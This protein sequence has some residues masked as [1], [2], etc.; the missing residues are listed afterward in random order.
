MGTRQA[1]H[2]MPNAR[3]TG[4]PVL[5]GEGHHRRRLVQ[6]TLH[7]ALPLQTRSCEHA[8]TERRHFQKWHGGKVRAQRLLQ[9]H[10]FAQAQTQAALGLGHGQGAPAQRRQLLPQGQVN[11][12]TRLH[13]RAHHLT[14]GASRQEVA[15]RVGNLSLGLVRRQVLHRLPWSSADADLRFHHRSVPSAL[16]QGYQPPCTT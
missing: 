16:N 11:A 2:F 6:Q 10:Q 8:G 14:C 7:P 9:H 13:R 12:L 1:L 3:P 5:Q 15:C 4:G